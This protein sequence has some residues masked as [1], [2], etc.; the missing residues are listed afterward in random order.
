VTADLDIRCGE[1]Y[2]PGDEL[3]LPARLQR[4]CSRARARRRPLVGRCAC[5]IWL[6][7]KPRTVRVGG[8]DGTSRHSRYSSAAFRNAVVADDQELIQS[9][10]L[11]ERGKALWDFRI[12]PGSNRGPRLSPADTESTPIFTWSRR[13]GYRRVALR[14]LGRRVG[15]HEQARGGVSAVKVI[16][17]DRA[18]G[19]QSGSTRWPTRTTAF[20]QGQ[21]PKPRLPR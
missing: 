6:L 2:A 11:R 8:L 13:R 17:R 20:A 19:R 5:D 1:R 18:P 4:Y 10:G 12:R 9:D 3:C 7:V 15:D 16:A 21:K 14:L